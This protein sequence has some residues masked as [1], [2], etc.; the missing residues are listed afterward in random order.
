MELTGSVMFAVNGTVSKLVLE[1]GVDAPQLTTIRA[2]GAALGLFVLV[3]VT[4]PRRLRVRP[5]ELGTLATY[6]VCGFF[7]VPMLYFV[8]IGRLPVGIG[9]LF[10]Y[11]APLL[12]ALWMRFVQGHAVK[13]RLWVGQVASLVGLAC[14]AEIWGE[15]RLDGLGIAAALA[16]ACLLAVYYLLSASGVTRRDPTS[17]TMYAYAFSAVAGALVRPLWSFDFHRLGGSS[18]GVPVWLL[19]TYII[20]GGSILPYLLLAGAMRHLPPTSVGILGMIEPVTATAVAWLVLGERLDVSQLAGGALILIGVT[21]AE[22]ARIKP[23]NSYRTGESA[24]NLEDQSAATL[25][26]SIHDTLQ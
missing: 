9:L 3:L 12:V 5:R 20:V 19:T 1:T 8:A 11:T 21:L 6:G 18:H 23:S 7:L 14:V 16:A 26:P 17:L 24:P 25:T 2:T 15:L 22:T 13:P 4:G 10:E